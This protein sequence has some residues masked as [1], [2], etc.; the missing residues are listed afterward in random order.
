[1]SEELALAVGQP[2]YEGLTYAEIE[3]APKYVNDAVTVAIGS[4]TKDYNLATYLGSLKGSSEKLDTLV[5]AIL[6]YASAAQVY[7]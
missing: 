4:D 3:M 2:L 1:M 6:N 5:D 7:F